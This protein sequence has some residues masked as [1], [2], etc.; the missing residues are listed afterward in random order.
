[1]KVYTNSHVNVS[2]EDHENIEETYD[3]YIYTQTGIYK[4]YK[5]HF[6]LCEYDSDIV[7]TREMQQNGHEYLV[8]LNNLKINKQK[9]LTSIPYQCY[10]VNRITRKCF[11]END[12]IFVKELDNDHFESFYF[13][14]DSLDKLN[15]IGSY[16][17]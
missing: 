6:F 14:V 9:I 13:I 10:F 4:K 3:T 2:V 7:P 16:I 17:K 15:D 5:K 12:I 8:E 1:M 11:L